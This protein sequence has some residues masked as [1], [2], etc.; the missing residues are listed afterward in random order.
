MG[1]VVR[2]GETVLP[3]EADGLVGH[4]VAHARVNGGRDGEGNDDTEG[5]Q[6][7]RNLL[8]TAK[9]LRNSVRSLLLLWYRPHHASRG[10]EHPQRPRGV[11]F[12]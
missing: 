1:P 4:E 12:G 3:L 2:I 7:G 5:K 9:T 8:E 11:H 6:L 10:P